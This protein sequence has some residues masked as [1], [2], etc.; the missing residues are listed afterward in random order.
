MSSFVWGVVPHYLS[1]VPDI[2]RQHGGLV[3][4]G[5]SMQLSYFIVNI[6]L[7]S[8]PLSPPMYPSVISRHLNVVWHADHCTPQLVSI[9]PTLHWLQ[10]LEAR[11]NEVSAKFTLT[12]QGSLF[13]KSFIITKIPTGCEKVLLRCKMNRLIK[14]LIHIYQISIFVM[15]LP[16]KCNQHRFIIFF[17]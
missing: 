1:L 17:F 15:E 11:R 2:S 4:K 8:S 16:C 10:L 12:Q 9:C 7:Y 14:P 3:C 6:K 5:K 13:H